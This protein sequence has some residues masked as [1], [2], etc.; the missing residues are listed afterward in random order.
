MKGLWF[1]ALKSLDKLFTTFVI[2]LPYMRFAIDMA[3]KVW[4]MEVVTRLL[5]LSPAAPP[6]IRLV[7]EWP[8]PN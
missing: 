4:S 2:G 8:N 5:W 3:W 1:R 7:K 6:V